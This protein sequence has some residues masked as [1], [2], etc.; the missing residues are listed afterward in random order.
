MNSSLD[1]N[2]L[3]LSGQ[4]ESAL[5]AIPDLYAVTPPRRTAHGRESDSLIIYLS[6]VGNSPLSSEAQAQ[7]LEQLAHKFYKT[8]G[9]LTAAMRTIAEALNLYL[10]DRNLRSTSVGR[11][12][13]GTLLLLALPADTL[14]LV[15]CGTVHAFLITP[16]GTQHL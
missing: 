2:L 1:L 8:T 15:Q 7:L 11:Q 13:I 14:Y 12:G 6:M 9:S 3:A 4:G 10:L 5:S 16:T